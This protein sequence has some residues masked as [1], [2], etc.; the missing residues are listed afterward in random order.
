MK[1][2]SRLVS[3]ALIGMTLV[4]TT[5]AQVQ[6]VSPAAATSATASSTV[7]SPEL[8]SFQQKVENFAKQTKLLEGEQAQKWLDRFEADVKKGTVRT[9]LPAGSS[10]AAEQASVYRFDSGNTQ[11][12]L[13]ISGQVRGASVNA[14]Y[15]SAGKL[16]ESLEMQLTHDETKGLA[17]VWRDGVLS[18]S[19]TITAAELPKDLPAEAKAGGPVMRGFS[20]K[21][22]NSCLANAGVS[23]W[24][25]ALLGTACGA[26]CVGTAGA[27]CVPCL[28]AAGGL[29]AGTVWFCVGK[30]T[31]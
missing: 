4:G 28:T 18:N 24:T 10:L 7:L 20:F 3:A 22:L 21:K 12:S 1:I 6:A 11:V 14:V 19:R 30:A 13:P 16:V 27:A 17:Q 2:S 29:G 8:A 15:D 31:S 23:S 9:H 25:L 5:A 26:A